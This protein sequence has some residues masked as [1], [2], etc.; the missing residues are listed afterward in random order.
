MTSFAN[1]GIKR[2]INGAIPHTP[3]G[4]PLVGPM[5]GVPN[6]WACCGS[7]IG[8]A[9]GAGCGTFLPGG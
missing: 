2:I 3:D 1:A 8:I 5:P 4:N 6:A 9:Q 7:S